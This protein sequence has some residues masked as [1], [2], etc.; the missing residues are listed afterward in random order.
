MWVKPFKLALRILN[1][2]DPSVE[3]KEA[4]AQKLSGEHKSLGQIILNPTLELI[5]DFF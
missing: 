1:A 5:I 3:H 2:P 4:H